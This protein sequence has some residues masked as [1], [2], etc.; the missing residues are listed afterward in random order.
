MQWRAE[1]A[2]TWV[3]MCERSGRIRDALLARGV[4]AISCD[5]MPTRRP[6]PHL[7]CDARE[8]IG[9][10][11][12]AMI[13]HPVCKT[14]TNAGAKH[15][16][17]NG[18]RINGMNFQRWNEMKDAAAFYTVFSD[19]HHI[20]LRAVENPVMHCHAAEL[21]GHRATQF[22]QPWWF[23]S[24]FQ[25][26]TGFKLYGLPKLRRER[27]RDSYFPWEIK[28]AVWLMGEGRDAQGRDREERRSETDPEVARA[29]A[30]YWGPLINEIKLLK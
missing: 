14:M 22:V 12:P 8:I 30:Q 9:W 1:Y 10:P 26:A 29:I 23:G 17:V 11:W 28:Q 2:H 4:P 5:T 27:E 15:L 16:Y 6:G 25:K 24:P 7:Q 19:A 3:I 21:I 13:A 20:P 18:K